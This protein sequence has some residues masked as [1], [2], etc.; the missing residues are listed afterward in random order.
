MR[1]EHWCVA[2][3]S[4]SFTKVVETLNKRL[5]VI[6]YMKIYDKCYDVKNKKSVT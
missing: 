5:Q 1:E 2:P 4:G 3:P 6:I